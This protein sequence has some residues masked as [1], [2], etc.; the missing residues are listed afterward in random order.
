MA[1]IL[2]VDDSLTVRT[3]LA[4]AL[5]AAGFRTVLCGSIAEAR[6]ALRSQRVA[7]AILD[8]QLPDG[9]GV[10]L[11]DQ[12]K[13]LRSARLIYSTVWLISNDDERPP[14]PRE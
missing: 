4:E 8:T 10:E 11:L 14:K 9:D 6:V 5:D 2:I 1:T 3:D 13:I 7:V 12:E